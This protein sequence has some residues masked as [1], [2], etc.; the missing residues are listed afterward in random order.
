MINLDTI[1]AFVSHAARTA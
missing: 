1:V